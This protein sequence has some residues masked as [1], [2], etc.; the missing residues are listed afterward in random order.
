[1]REGFQ[2]LHEDDVAVTYYKMFLQLPEVEKEILKA[3]IDNQ[4]L[5]F[6]ITKTNIEENKYGVVGFY[7][8]VA[9]DFKIEEGD[10]E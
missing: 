10:D 6:R 2:L 5:F 7:T 9:T 4:G 3:I 1:M 8:L